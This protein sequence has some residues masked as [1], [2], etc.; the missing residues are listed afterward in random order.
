MIE[1]AS[2]GAVLTGEVTGALQFLAEQLPALIDLCQLI[3]DKV[4]LERELAERERLAMLG[5]IA[6]S[7]SHNLRNP[8]SSMKAILQVQLENVELAT[9]VKKDLE[10]VLSEL[11]R[12]SSKLNQL[13][14]YSRS[15]VRA[16]GNTE[17]VASAALI[18]GVVNLLRRDAE[19]RGVIIEFLKP[20]NEIRVTASEEALHEVF[21]NLIVNSVEAQ[22]GGGRI[23]IGAH[24]NN[25]CLVVEICDTGPG[26]SA[27]MRSKIFEPFYTTK[28]SGTG[29]G[30]AIVS[31]RL[32][33][34]GGSLGVESP[35]SDGRGT[36]FTV[37]LPLEAQ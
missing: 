33:E 5:Q 30:L 28:A 25:G 12:L 36:R 32:G 2:T 35:V 6:A 17:S 18:D 23:E 1:A 4:E 3:Q 20:R 27:D 13:L 15:P 9:P 26:I 16:A 11:E 34:I 7:V 24:R 37:T 31:R 21:T 22:P 29:L 14:Q 8:L 10:L 19:Q